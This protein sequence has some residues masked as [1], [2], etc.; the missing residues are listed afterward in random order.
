MFLEVCIFQIA[1]GL[2]STKNF[3]VN[4]RSVNHV[5]AHKEPK[6]ANSVFVCKTIQLPSERNSLQFYFS[7]KEK[8]TVVKIKCK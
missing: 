2:F 7:G 8:S 5:H 3:L 6:H 1:L 4:E